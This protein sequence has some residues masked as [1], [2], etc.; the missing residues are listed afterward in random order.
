MKKTVCLLLI[1]AVLL[2]LAA[3]GQKQ[4]RGEPVD[5][6]DPEGENVPDN[7]LGGDGAPGALVGG[8]TPSA[9]PELSEDRLAVFEKALEGLVGVSY[10][11][12]AYLGSQVVAGMNHCYLCQAQLV[13]P[14]A[15]PSYKLMYIYEAPD[16]SCEILSVADLDFGAFCSYG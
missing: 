3:C 16:G 12:V 14:G 8:W 1:A 11:P 9:S 6:R 15:Q 7:M 10:T 4:D 13:Y 5:L 2:S